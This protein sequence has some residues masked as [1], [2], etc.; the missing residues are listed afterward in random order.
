MN[1]MKTIKL[2]IM[3][4]LRGTAFAHTIQF[5]KNV[6]LVA[7]CEKNPNNMKKIAPYLNE[8]TKVFENFDD[9]IHCGMDG[10]I[11][12]N[13]FHEHAPYAIKAFE[14][15]V[16][17]LSETTAAI[18][19]GECVDL[20]EA[21]EKYNGRYMLA[22]NCPYFKAVHAMKMRIQS[23]KSGRVMY[24]EAEY[25]H[26]SSREDKENAVQQKGLHID[27]DNLHWRQC[28][29]ANYYNMHTLG[30]LMYVTDSEPVK[31]CAKTIGFSDFARLGGNVRDHD[32][33]VVLTQ[34][35]NGALF[36]TSGCNGYAPSSKWYRIACENE[37]METERYEWR[38]E[39][40]LVTKDEAFVE[41]SYP[42]DYEESG[43]ITPEDDF[44]PADAAAAGHGGIDFHIVYHFVKY[45]RGKE[46]PF[47][48]VYRS[49]RLSAVAILGWYSILSG[50]EL[51]VPDFRIPEERDR[52][53]ND[54]R[55]P[56]AKKYSDL[57]LPCRVEDRDKFNL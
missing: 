12:C 46:E 49:A 14:A 53:R 34:M 31:V 13:Y 16:A 1:T 23:G 21:A 15:G 11:L 44:T 51:D 42:N 20:V 30:P 50:R 7:V 40:L 38:E 52:V 3:G 10:V 45:L 28:M 55:T 8:S 18:S 4:A 56:I 5:V 48:N 37:T 9:F 22:A 36:N 19:L 17:V 43:L 29:P 2:G 6:E 41:V 27:Y 33:S 32:G 54:Y 47:F 57:Q 39:K 25:N 35:D 24:A 26:G